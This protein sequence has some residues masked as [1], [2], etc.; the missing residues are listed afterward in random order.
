ML[1]SS[2]Y[3]ANYHKDFWMHCNL[4]VFVFVIL[5]KTEEE[6]KKLD[7]HPIASNSFPPYFS[8][9]R[10]CCSNIEAPYPHVTSSLNSKHTHTQKKNLKSGLGSTVIAV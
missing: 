6:T 5:S 4:F 8:Y 1:Y 2:L 7:E 9:C 10:L 3:F